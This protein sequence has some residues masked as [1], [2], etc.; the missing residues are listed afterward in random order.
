MN[1]TALLTPGDLLAKT[2]KVHGYP[3]SQET[4]FGHS[5]FVVESARAILYNIRDHVGMPDIRKAWATVE[6]LVLFSSWLH[7]LGKA[8]NIF[9]AMLCNK[10]GLTRRPHPIRHEVLT[11]LLLVQI[12]GKLKEWAVSVTEGYGEEFLW[13][14]SW[15]CGGHHLAL[16]R[17]RPRV[18]NDA[19]RLVRFEGVRGRFVFLGRHPDVRRLIT[20]TAHEL[21]VALESPEIDDQRIALDGFEFSEGTPLQDLVD[22]YV[23]AS[24]KFSARL[25]PGQSAILAFAKA[26]LIAADVAGSALPKRN[27][28]PRTWIM[29]ALSEGWGAQETEMVVRETLQSRVLRNFQREIAESRSSVTVTVAG[30]GNG[31]TAAAYAWAGTWAQGRKL[32]FCYP[33]TGTASAGFEDY[34]LAQ[35]EIERTLIHG[36]AHVDVEQMLTINE[37]DGLEENGLK[38]VLQRDSLTAWSKQ[39]MACTVDTVLGLMQNHRRPLFSFPVLA[40]GVFVFDEVHSY[41]IRMFGALLR[42]L[43]TFPEVP[44]LLMSASIP[45]RRIEQLQRVVGERWN[46]VIG[47]DPGLEQLKRYS[48]RQEDDPPRCWEH[49]RQVLTE[50]GKVLWA[51]NRVP[52][53]RETY[54]DAKIRIT[55]WGL[56]V[57]PILYHSRFRYRDRVDR[58][59]EVLKAFR[60]SGPVLVICTQVCEMSLDISA[61]LLVTAVAPFP[62]LMQRLGRLNRRAVPGHDGIDPQPKPCLIYPFTCKDGRPYYSD[63]LETA[64]LILRDLTREV[65]SQQDLAVALA[66]VQNKEETKD[67]SSWIDGLWQSDQRELHEGDPTIS[68]LLE[69]DIPMVRDELARRQERPSPSTLAPWVIPM[70]YQRD[71]DLSCRFGGIPAVPDSMIE[72]EEETGAR[73]RKKLWEVW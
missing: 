64:L 70:L 1:S 5:K 19:E 48:I 29:E 47:G 27:V 35:T 53:A 72:Y 11:A 18:T 69:A 23:D 71:V 8:T 9:Q 60:V 12:E 46:G 32:I 58:Q 66:K 73:W 15:I 45:K 36:R 55:S 21:K 44:V 34:L 59:N 17:D 28:A 10:S 4:L 6:P 22:E 67:G 62:S 41:D 7:D 30:C 37:M 2:E 20:A 65:C 24:E 52:D 14:A 33:T 31:K 39:V 49:V 56:A 42:F 50:G 43:G 57:K 63:D 25:D 40:R 13:M 26:V 16:H 38:E 51:C 3:V 68:V 54:E 61:D